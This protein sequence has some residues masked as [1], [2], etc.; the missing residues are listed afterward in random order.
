MR[1]IIVFNMVSVDGFFAG[2][3][4]NL[5]WH[6]VDDEFNKFAVGQTKEFGA[7]M[8]GRTTYSLFENFWP[9]VINN[10]KFSKEDH[11][12][13]EIIDNT[14]KIVFSKTLKTVTWKNSKLFR[15]IESPEIEELKKES[16]KDIAIFGSGTV[17]QALTNLNLIDE[18]RLMVNPVVL[19]VGKPLFKNL[20]EKLNLKLLNARIFKSGNVLLYY[21]PIKLHSF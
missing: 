10:P 8:F 19:G 7:L 16:G 11:E 14:Q 6:N 9:K 3:D 2:I 13:A 12:I 15:D 17:V 21:Q 4:G 20:K 1:K 18:Y 5:D